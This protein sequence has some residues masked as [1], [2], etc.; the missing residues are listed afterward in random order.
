MKEKISISD[1]C[2][3]LSAFLLIA[4]CD[5]TFEPLQ[6]NDQYHF[7]IF[8]YLDASALADTQWVRIVPPRQQLDAPADV[9]E[10]KVILENVKTGNTIIMQD[11]LF[12]EGSGFN[13][14]NFYTLAD[15]E[16]DQTYRVKAEH[17]DG[18]TSWA[19]LT[20]PEEFPTPLFILDSSFVPREF[21]HSII[22]PGVENLI[23]VQI[24]Y[25]VRNNVTNQIR[26]FAFSYRNSAQ[27]HEFAYGG[28]YIADVIPQR[29]EGTIF[30]TLNIT[31]F[32]GSN[33]DLLHRQIFVAVGGPEWNEEIPDMSDGVYAQMESFSNV[34]NG[35][36][37]MVG[38]YSKIIPYKT[39]ETEDKSNFAPCEIEVPFW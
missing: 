6:E 34:E 33:Y 24:W 18:R 36:G 28:A 23:D 13:Y 35:L 32:F 19:I 29:E 2:I 14:I 31:S 38:V 39:C 5:Q 10:I 22:M 25:F 12:G 21:H 11:S 26:K 27:W 7:T 17:P 9:S 30:S 8:G 3:L 16:P 20:T 15:I 4:G 1:I 37:Y